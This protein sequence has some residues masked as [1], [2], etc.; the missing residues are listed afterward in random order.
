MSRASAD[1]NLRYAVRA[2][3]RRLPLFL[4]P[5]LLVPAVAVGI[6]LVQKKKYTTTASLLFRN[7]QFDQMIFGASFTPAETDPTRQA[8]TNLDLVSLPRVAALTAARLHLSESQVSSAVTES[9]RD[10][11]D[12]VSVQASARSPGFAAQLANT[13]AA[14]F[15]AFRRDADR[16]TLASAELPLQKQIASLPRPVRYGTLGQSLESRLGQL[17]M[18]ASLQT[19]DAELVQPAQVPS[20]PSSPKLLR[21]AALGIFF[22]IVLGIA[23]VLLAE[24][25][26][27]RLRDRAELEQ[28]FER[29]LLGTIPESRKLKAAD[30]ALLAA[31]EADR[32]AFRMLWTNLRYFTLSR[33]V[34]SVLIT[35]ADRGDGKSTVAWGLGLAAASAGKRTLVI[36]ADLRNP[37]FAERFELPRRPGL[38]SA[39]T[40]DATFDE[41]I[42]RVTLPRSTDDPNPTHWM[43]VLY[44]GPRPPDPTDLL[45]SHWVAD[46]LGWVEERYDLIVA[47]TAPAAVVS[48]TI[49][50]I[51]LVDGVIVV[52][53]LGNTLRD[54]AQQLRQQLDHLSAPLLGIVVNSL[55]EDLLYEYPYGEGYEPPPSRTQRA[56]NGA[57][58]RS[59]VER[60]SVVAV[61][62]SDRD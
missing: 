5:L 29:P 37:S 30:A 14:E 17:R 18:L 46:F 34:R 21:N 59:E 47:D 2:L 6:S 60:A 11:S 31:A 41:A 23:L 54:H 49:P 27:R 50:L 9:S 1:F 20:G 43:D 12:L 13:F 33:G 28:I 15:I 19:G 39:L 45:Q 25:F 62:P 57:R 42:M 32:E 24:V 48:D 40:G 52:T 8:A 44:A 56:A 7:P 51:T 38:T 58:P 10:Q 16:A 55:Q 26:D 36:E 3:R 4:L 53:R 35:S 61:P 22:G